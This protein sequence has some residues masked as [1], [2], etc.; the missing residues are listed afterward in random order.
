MSINTAMVSPILAFLLC[1]S[2]AC[3]RQDGVQMPEPAPSAL[4]IMGADISFVPQIRK[5][6]YKVQN[7]AGKTEDMLLILKKAGVNTIRLRLWH[8]PAGGHSGLAEVADFAR[9]VRA[10][11]MKVLLAPHY[12]DT[13]A[14]PEKQIK[15]A[16]WNG[17][18]WSILA[19]SVYQYT[20]LVAREV[21]PDFIQIGNEINKGLLWPEGH[22]SN[23]VA[24]RG[25]LQ[26][27]IQGAKEGHPSAQIV[28]QYAGHEGAEA[29]FGGLS[30]LDYDMIG[31]SYYPLWHGKDLDALTQ[32][33]IRLSQ[34]YDKDVFIAETSYPFTLGW[35][36][37]TNNIIGLESQLLPAYAAT[38]QGQKA[39]LASIR[40]ISKKAPRYAG[41]CYWGAEWVSFKGSAATDGSTWENQ[42]FW[43]FSG[44]ALPV[45]QVYGNQ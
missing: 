6:G 24:F 15:P 8:T 7:P 38:P 40:A 2:A 44:S 36:D 29:F 11:G 9:E 35:N 21:Q 34:V 1:L 41:F 19:D 42:A 17:L 13:W 22:A 45:L 43:G 31:L 30:A 4:P 3:N 23:P 18:S 39:F 26:A 37:N 25:L 28:L 27:G 33:I 32:N 16:A 20:R 5:A 10:Q 12:A 14:D